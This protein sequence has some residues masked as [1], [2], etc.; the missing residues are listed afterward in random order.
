M[1][2]VVDIYTFCW[3]EQVRLPYFLKLW[4]PLARS[5][6]IFDNG[7][8]DN[9]KIIAKTFKN[10]IWNTKD[11]DT[12]GVLHEPILT[13]LKNNCWKKS[14]DADLVFVGDIDEILFYKNSTLLDLFLKSFEGFS[15]FKPKA[16]TMISQ[17]I[18]THEGMIYDNEDFKFGFKEDRYSKIC[19]FSPNLIKEINYDHGC[20]SCS[21][22]GAIKYYSSDDFYLLHYHWLGCEFVSNRRIQVRQRYSS[23]AIQHQAITAYGKKGRYFR[24]AEETKSDYERLMLERIKIF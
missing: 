18:P 22:E 6:T 9:S 12:G 13:N 10:V 20:H 1:K 8:S 2:P 17:N 16:Y 23:W 14:R 7:S 4:S 11:Y 15:L 3:N 24:D 5:I 21:P 19:L